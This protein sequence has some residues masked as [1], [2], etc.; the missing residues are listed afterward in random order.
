MGKKDV[1]NIHLALGE[2]CT[3]EHFKFCGDVTF[4]EYGHPD[5]TVYVDAIMM[6]NKVA[7]NTSYI[8]IIIIHKN[9]LYASCP[10]M[11]GENPTLWNHLFS[12][13][14]KTGEKIVHSVE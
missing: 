10:F 11:L 1:N 4:V 14:N 5:K 9:Q 8:S 3:S 2:A 6:Q 13:T 7:E 12:T